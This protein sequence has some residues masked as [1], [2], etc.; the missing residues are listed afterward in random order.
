MTMKRIL[1]ALA[2]ACAAASSFGATLNPVQ[3][4]NPAGSS[5]GQAIVSTGASSAPAWGSVGINGIA[6]IAANT[7]LANATGSSASPTAFAMPSCTGASNALGYTSGT[8]I[9]WNSAINAATLGGATFAAPGSIGGTTAAAGSFT[10]LGA[11]GLISPA[12]PAGISGNKT[13]SSVTAGSLGEFV[14]AV[15]GTNTPITTSGVAQNCTSISLTAGDWDVTGSVF[16]AAAAGAGLWTNTA[17]SISA[18]SATQSSNSYYFGQTGQSTGAAVN[19]SYA[20]PGQRVNVSTTTTI[21]L[22]VQ[23]TYSSGTMNYQCQLQARRR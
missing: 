15:I 7:V 18:V 10:T 8:G 1:T 12:Y 17:S 21:Y 20:V 5:S 11:S 16:W 6:A 22:V 13:G 3:L 9:V 19:V 23:S 14:Q 4:L 2:L